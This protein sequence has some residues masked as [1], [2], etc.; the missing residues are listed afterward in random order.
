MG[1]IRKQIKLEEDDK[2][3]SEISKL[4]WKTIVSRAIR[5]SAVC[6]LNSECL[7][8]KKV[9]RQYTEIKTKEY[10]Y[11]LSAEDA[12]TAFAYRSGTLDIKCHKAY[13]HSDLR[14]RACGEDQEDVDH[15]VN[16]CSVVNRNFLVNTDIESEDVNTIEEVVKTLNRFTQIHL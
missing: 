4:A 9:T 16:K 13:M 2:K 8:L 1:R 15:I 3:I 12:R 10:L 5:K 7:K 14:C 11:K 6:T